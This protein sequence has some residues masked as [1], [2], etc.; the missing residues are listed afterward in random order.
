MAMIWFVVGLL[1]GALLSA[2][3]VPLLRVTDRDFGRAAAAL[4]AVA[5]LMFAVRM[6]LE[7][8]DHEDV[9]GENILASAF[10]SLLVAK[11]V[12]GFAVAVAIAG[13]FIRPRA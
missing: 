10:N 2:P 1:G 6:H 12:F 5:V 13:I 8:V 3:I 9:P 4:T 7:L 11:G